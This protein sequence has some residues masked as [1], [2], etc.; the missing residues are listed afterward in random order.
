M[1]GA[2]AA[3]QAVEGLIAGPDSLLLADTDSAD[4][5]LPQEVIHG[6]VVAAG[7]GGA[8]AVG[9]GRGGRRAARRGV[10]SAGSRLTSS[11]RAARGR[12][13]SP[14]CSS[15]A[16]V[17]AARGSA[18][19]G[20]SRG[21]ATSA[22][23]A[24]SVDA[25]RLVDAAIAVVVQAVVADLV[26]GLG[27]AAEGRVAVGGAFDLPVEAALVALEGAGVADDVLIVGA[28]VVGEAVGDAGRVAGA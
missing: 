7:A 4:A 27:V 13:I 25:T 23:T 8:A 28:A 26:A 3:D 19:G 22:A 14:T 15:R 6:A 10:A 2:F 18:G 20:R 16:A 9:A 12:G 1:A 11:A 24:G 17:A 21:A 5:G